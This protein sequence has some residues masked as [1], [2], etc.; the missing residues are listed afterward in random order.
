MNKT[1]PDMQGAFALTRK[2]ETGIAMHVIFAA[3]LAAALGGH[4]ADVFTTLE[5]ECVHMPNM[6][7]HALGSCHLSMHVS[8][9]VDP[10]T[11]LSACFSCMHLLTCDPTNDQRSYV[12]DTKQGITNERAPAIANLAL[13]M[14]PAGARSHRRLSAAAVPAAVQT[15]THAIRSACLVLLPLPCIVIQ[16]PSA[17][18][19]C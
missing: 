11:L 6:I 15:R 5:L 18:D 10:Q 1:V 8:C 16:Q 2:M 3:V 4:A 12:S 14:R 9:T 17:L 7:V 13:S 19:A